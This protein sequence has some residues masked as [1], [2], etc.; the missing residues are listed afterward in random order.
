VPTKD[1]IPPCR[2]SVILARAAPVG[3]IFRRGPSKLV[4]LIKWHTD[5]DT[6]E[7][8]QWFKGRIYE[9]HSDLS[10]DGSLL[11]YFAS[12]QQLLGPFDKDHFPAWTAVSRPP[13]L[14]ALALWPGRG[15]WDVGV[16]LFLDNNTVWFGR[17]HRAHRGHKPSGLNI[18]TGTEQ[19]PRRFIRDGWRQITHASPI[20]GGSLW[21][22]PDPWWRRAIAVN[23]WTSPFASHSHNCLLIDLTTGNRAPMYGV[24]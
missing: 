21:E 4:E 2:L 12:K 20:V 1:G 6:F 7:R 19:P 17:F 15:I 11:V 24:T 16:S 8:G 23:A 18:V 22:K 3:V 10:P 5:T 14:T 13:W 9:D